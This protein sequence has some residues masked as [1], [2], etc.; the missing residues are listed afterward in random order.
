MPLYHQFLT[1]KPKAP[2]SEL[3]QL[4]KSCAKLVENAGGVVRQVENH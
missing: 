1:I 4:V 2:A 3:V